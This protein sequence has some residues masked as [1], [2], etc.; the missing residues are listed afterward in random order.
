MHRVALLA[1]LTACMDPG[2]ASVG[3]ALDDPQ[4]PPRGDADIRAWLAAGSYRSWRCEPASHPGRA[5]SPHGANR[6]CNNDALA[7]AGDFAVGA[8]AVKE[9]VER[10]EII[11]YAVS[12]KLGDDHWYWYEAQGDHVFANGA[13]AGN[14]TGCHERAARDYVFTVVP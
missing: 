11:G 9:L 1:V 3:D 5:P 6:I 13:D 12:R 2:P 14:C 7:P 8:A 4:L 10:D